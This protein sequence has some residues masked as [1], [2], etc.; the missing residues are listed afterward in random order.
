M[1]LSIVQTARLKI[2]PL[3]KRHAA[4]LHPILSD[5]RIYTYIPQDPPSLSALQIRYELLETRSS[6]DGTE[7]WLNWALR[8]QHEGVCIGTIQA[9]ISPGQTALIAYELG[10]DYWG[11]G[12]AT[13]ALTW[14][15]NEWKETHEV[16][17]AEAL[18]DTRNQA[19]I[20]L[21]E[22]FAFERI[23]TIENADVFKGQP[24]DE[25]RYERIL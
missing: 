1:Q 12:Y 11:K 6:P 3:E 5:P 14:L 9:T 2:E 4:E 23:E 24:S 22:R 20:R 16:A 21:L 7:A 18:V 15:L 19:S 10:P 13:E 17:T 25:Y 8:L